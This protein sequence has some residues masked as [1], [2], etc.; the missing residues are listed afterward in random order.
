MH[1]VFDFA[2]GRA[3]DCPRCATT[4]YFD[5]TNDSAHN[6][7][8]V[9]CRV[10]TRS[11]R[12][13]APDRQAAS[14]P[15]A[16]A[17]SKLNGT[18]NRPKLRGPQR[19]T[20]GEPGGSPF[21]L[22]LCRSRSAQNRV[23]FASDSHRK[24]GVLSFCSARSPVESSSPPEL[25]ELTQSLYSSVLSKASKELEKYSAHACKVP[26]MARRNRVGGFGERAT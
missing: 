26:T 15:P 3:V 13:Q 6:G 12:P 17:R 8:G 10:L 18:P 14:S 20:K 11:P 9:Q 19:N 24:S 1:A 4:N 16:Q 2:R 25:M 23:C 21:A 22:L 7:S 5:T